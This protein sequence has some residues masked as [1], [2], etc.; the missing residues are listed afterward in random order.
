MRIVFAIILALL[1][2]TAAAQL[3]VVPPCFPLVNGTHVGT[4]RHISGDV[5]QH[6]FW[7]CSPRG[8]APREYGFSCMHGQC[9][10]AVMAGVMAA[11][12]STSTKLT[13]AQSAYT[14][15]VAYTCAGTVLT[16]STDR[17]KLCRERVA[18]MR[19]LGSSWFGGAQ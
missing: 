3:L 12:A 4:P 10:N 18:I 15:H 1:S 2:T 11:I 19:A 8:G 16:E 9:S 14:Q 6:V 13:A 5:G 7:A 17:G